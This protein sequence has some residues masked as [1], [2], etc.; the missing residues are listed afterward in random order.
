M[1]FTEQDIAMLSGVAS[2]TYLNHRTSYNQTMRAFNDIL[3]FEIGAG[4]IHQRLYNNRCNSA[5][6]PPP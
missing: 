3:T 2:R 1:V 6:S 5:K 4:F